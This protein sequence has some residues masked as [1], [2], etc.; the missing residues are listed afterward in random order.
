MADDAGLM[1][2][3]SFH[4]GLSPKRLSRSL[5]STTRQHLPDRKAG[6]TAEKRDELGSIVLGKFDG[7]KK[8]RLNVGCSSIIVGKAVEKKIGVDVNGKREVPEGAVG[9]DKQR[10]QAPKLRLVTADTARKVRFDT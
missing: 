4:G 6:E 3:A 1:Y 2:S 9:G 10:D 5:I 8:P 7:K